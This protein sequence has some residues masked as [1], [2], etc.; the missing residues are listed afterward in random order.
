[1]LR[2]TRRLLIKVAF[3]GTFFWIACL[4]ILRIQSSIIVEKEINPSLTKRPGLDYGNLA[5]YSLNSRDAELQRRFIKGHK[6]LNEAQSLGFTIRNNDK[7]LENVIEYESLDNE[8]KALIGKGLIH[9]K[10][11]LFTPEEP[12]YPNAPGMNGFICQFK[13][14]FNY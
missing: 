4:I 3:V 9:P 13:I 7:K 2:K 14:I 10:W 12:E 6:L 5:S 1:M 8:T 11:E